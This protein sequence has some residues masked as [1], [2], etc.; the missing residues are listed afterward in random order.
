MLD[1]IILVGLMLLIGYAVVTLVFVIEDDVSNTKR[2]MRRHKE[3]RG[4]RITYYINVKTGEE[5]YR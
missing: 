1:F 5:V 3:I 2:Y 4:K